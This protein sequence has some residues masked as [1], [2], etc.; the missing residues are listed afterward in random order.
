MEVDVRSTEKLLK[1]LSVPSEESRKRKRV[2]SK[3][4]MHMESKQ[5][6]PQ[7]IPLKKSRFLEPLDPSVLTARLEERGNLLSAEINK[8]LQALRVIT[9][10]LREKIP[11]EKEL[12]KKNNNYK[13]VS[14]LSGFVVNTHSLNEQAQLLLKNLAPLKNSN[15]EEKVVNKSFAIIASSEFATRVSQFIEVINKND[16]TKEINYEQLKEASMIINEITAN[17][18]IKD[19]FV[20]LDER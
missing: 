12:S 6:L 20:M 7:N 17:I 11:Q 14:E 3:G 1:K 19:K 2:V 18:D 9:K 4:A 5:N 8:A 15:D 10:E 13:Q 16:S